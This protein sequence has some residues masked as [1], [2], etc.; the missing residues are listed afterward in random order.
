MNPPQDLP[1][2]IAPQIY[3]KALELQDLCKQLQHP[4]TI[5]CEAASTTLILDTERSYALPSTSISSDDPLNKIKI[6][7]IYK[8]PSQ[9]FPVT[10]PMPVTDTWE[11]CYTK[12]SEAYRTVASPS[13]YN[14]IQCL[15]YGYHLGALLLDNPEYDKPIKASRTK[16]WI[17]T[18]KLFKAIGYEQI[19]Q[20]K[21]LTLKQ[22]GDLS[23]PDLIS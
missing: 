15:A 8:D 4:G 17:R 5:I 12:T 13:N 9:I 2:W 14:R 16:A 23:K 1:T 20:T 10:V 19:Y 7:L 11:H 3:Y 18:Y 6:D 22:I 21:K